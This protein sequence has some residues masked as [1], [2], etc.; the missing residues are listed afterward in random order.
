MIPTFENPVSLQTAKAD[1]KVLGVENLL[2]SSEV[3]VRF[4]CRGG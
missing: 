3:M 1:S 4:I 2:S